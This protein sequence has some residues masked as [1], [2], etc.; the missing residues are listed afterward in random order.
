MHR[1]RQIY[2]GVSEE[3]D[4]SELFCLGSHLLGAKIPTYAY[5]CIQPCVIVCVYMHIATYAYL[6]RRTHRAVKEAVGT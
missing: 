6:E 2:I 4:F 1:F 3:A 5:S